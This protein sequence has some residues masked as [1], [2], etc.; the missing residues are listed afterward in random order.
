MVRHAQERV[1]VGRQIHADHLGL[2]VHRVIDHVVN[3]KAQVIRVYLP[4]DANT[5]LSVTDHCLRSRNYVNVIVA[6]K[7]RAT[8]ADHGP[9]DQALH[10]RHRDMGVGVERPRGGAGRRDG[11]LRRRADAGD[12]G[13][14]GTA[15]SAPAGD[16]IRVVNV[17][18]LMKLQPSTEHPHGLTDRDFDRLFTRDR[19]AI[20]A[21]HGYPWWCIG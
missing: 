15:A 6:G 5:L 11:L 20:F 21:F 18:D 16:K 14:G 3:K 7:R 4:P 1:R 13:R 8:V 17:V 10:G 12:A 19:P 9:G 2:L